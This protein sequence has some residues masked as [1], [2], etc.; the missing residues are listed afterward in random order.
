[1]SSKLQIL[2]AKLYMR[3]FTIKR[4]N[5]FKPLFF[6]F[7]ILSVTSSVTLNYFGTDVFSC[8]Q[9]GDKSIGFT[10]FFT[11]NRIASSE[12]DITDNSFCCCIV[13]DFKTKHEI[14]SII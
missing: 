8:G 1:V 9:Y 14:N 11:H 5:S 3:N 13:S 4:L 10:N 7:F 12:F 6:V 2:N